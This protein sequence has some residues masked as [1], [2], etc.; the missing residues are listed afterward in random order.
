[1]GFSLPPVLTVLS[2]W[3]W[4]VGLLGFVDT[5]QALFLLCLLAD[6]AV[7]RTAVFFCLKT[8]AM[9]LYFV[10]EASLSHFSDVFLV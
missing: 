2:F 5:G 7:P 3:T 9:V 1:M 8:I 10:F 4:F 6:L